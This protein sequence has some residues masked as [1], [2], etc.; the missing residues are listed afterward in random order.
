MTYESYTDQEMKDISEKM[1]D[2][3][4]NFYDLIGEPGVRPWKPELLDKWAASKENENDPSSR[5]AAQFMLSLWDPNGSWLSGEFDLHEAISVW[6]P[7][8]I[9]AFA[10]WVLR[11]WWPYDEEND[12]RRTKR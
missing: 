12:L 8:N 5:C 7:R 1:S 2:I 4:E 11:P 3:A 10:V 9:S 6:G